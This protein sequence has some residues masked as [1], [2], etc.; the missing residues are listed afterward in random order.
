MAEFVGPTPAQLSQ[1][2]SDDFNKTMLGMAEMFKSI[3]TQK[4]SSEAAKQK[5]DAE[6]QAADLKNEQAVLDTLVKNSATGSLAE[7]AKTPEGQALIADLYG[8]AGVDKNIIPSIVSQLANNPYTA[9]QIHQ[10]IMG[11]YAT[12]KLQDAY[13]ETGETPPSWLQVEQAGQEATGTNAPA[14]SDKLLG[15]GPQQG[16]PT[17]GVVSPSGTP[18]QVA[19][20]VPTPTLGQANIPGAGNVTG[21]AAAPASA[22]TPMPSGTSSN[23]Y[24]GFMQQALGNA[25]EPEAPAG[26]ATEPPEDLA[27]QTKADARA[28]ASVIAKEAGPSAA[29]NYLRNE[30]DPNGIPFLTRYMAANPS[31]YYKDTDPKHMEAYQAALDKTIEDRK[32]MGLQNDELT[33]NLETLREKNKTGITYEK[34]LTLQALM[35]AS[36]AQVNAKLASAAYQTNNAVLT[37]LLASAQDREDEANKMYAVV[38]AKG[39]KATVADVAHLNSLVEQ[40]NSYYRQANRVVTTMHVSLGGNPKEAPQF[41]DV[42]AYVMSKDGGLV[43]GFSNAITAAMQGTGSQTGTVTREGVTEPPVPSGP[44]AGVGAAGQTRAGSGAVQR[45][46]VPTGFTPEQQRM[47]DDILKELGQ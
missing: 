7:V 4:Q 20:V 46:Q 38:T 5:A 32:N 25:P 18:M 15:T 22:P 3:A 23:P 2:S 12:K 44:A 14:A 24:P 43:G 6:Q 1:Q 39:A 31:E 30:L 33:I 40:A 35:A 21:V 37:K 47:A 36:T 19:P 11:V 10:G 27:D 26:A 9:D 45:A 8:K 42:P 41:S 17:Q 13:A 29:A 16:A 28:Q 34:A